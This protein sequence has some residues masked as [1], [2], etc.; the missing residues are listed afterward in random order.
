MEPVQAL[1][2]AGRLTVEYVESN[3]SPLLLLTDRPPTDRAP[4]W[5]P[6]GQELYF[7]HAANLVAV[8]IMAFPAYAMNRYWV[9]GKKDKNRL[10]TEVAE[11][12]VE[13]EDLVNLPNWLP[14]RFRLPPLRDVHRHAGHP[15]QSPRLVA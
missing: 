13:N 15:G 1:R 9:W 7:R 2:R 10:T 4:S 5:S 12:M 14:L 11:R 8:T 6:D 3:G